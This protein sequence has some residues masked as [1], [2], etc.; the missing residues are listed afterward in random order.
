M[1]HDSASYSLVALEDRL[2]AQFDG[3]GPTLVALSGGVDSAVALAAA[4]RALGAGQV[5]ALTAVSAAVPAEEIAEA[6]AVAAGLG[7]RH[8]TENTGELSVEGY[9]ANGADR[10]AF[11]KTELIGVARR[12]ADRLGLTTVATGTQAD[13]MRAGF[14]PGIAAAAWL[15]ART[16][17]AD[18]GLGKSEVRALAERWGL[19]VW[20][21][22]AAACLA[23][24]IAYGLT[25]TP[26]RLDRVGRAERALRAVL[27]EYELPVRDLRVRDLGDRVRIEVDRELA[28]MVAELWDVSECLTRSGFS[29]QAVVAVE[30]EAFRSGSLNQVLPVASPMVL[31]VVSPVA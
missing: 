7:V 30:I 14:R 24:R 26:A 20:D 12:V 28:P 31:P 25:V 5:A 21:K 17:L 11:C 15:G 19:P 4:A 27:A 6:A 2:T 18:A 23:S 8:L 3:Y 13:D 22:P 10:C 1:T 9:R 29:A 16:P